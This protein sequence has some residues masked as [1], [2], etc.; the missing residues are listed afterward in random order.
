[1][2]SLQKSLVCN[3]KNDCPDGTDEIACQIDLPNGP[4]TPSCSYGMFPCDGGSCYP[5]AVRCDGR[6]DCK[7]G[8]DESDCSKKTRIYQ[9][10]TMDI[11]ERYL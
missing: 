11:D 2:L 3:H 5:L 4:A 1:M 10:M 8:Y 6:V 9:I 7:D